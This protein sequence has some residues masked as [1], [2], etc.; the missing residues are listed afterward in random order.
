[1]KQESWKSKAAV[2]AE[3]IAKGLCRDC[4]D[5]A[6]PGKHSCKRHLRFAVQRVQRWRARRKDNLPR[7]PYTGEMISEKEYQERYET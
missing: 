4:N 3:H 6:E 2:R 7:D 5:V 1:M